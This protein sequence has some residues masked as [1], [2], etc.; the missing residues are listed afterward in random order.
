MTEKSDITYNDIG[1]LDQQKQ[2]IKEAVRILE[3]K[4]NRLNCL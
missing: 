2:E 1:G 4:L 3:F